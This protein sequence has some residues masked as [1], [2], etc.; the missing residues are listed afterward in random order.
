FVVERASYPFQTKFGSDFRAHLFENLLDGEEHVALVKGRI[1]PGQTT[2]VRVHA[3]HLMGD[4][5]GCLTT[6]SGEYLEAALKKINSEG[7][8][9]L[10]YLRQAISKTEKT[11]EADDLMNDHRDYGIGAQILRALGVHK[12]CL[13]TNNP[14]K[15]VGLKGY[16]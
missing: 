15:R 4:V 14:M 9:V 5:L 1:E 13:L 3:E 16:G 12:I 2:L 10:V 8:G 7:S 11:G 6:R